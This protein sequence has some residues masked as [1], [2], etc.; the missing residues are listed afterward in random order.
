M[1]EVIEYVRAGNGPALVEVESYRWFGHST[2]D[3]GVYRT[4]EEVAEWK[5][6]DPLKKYRTYLT[7]NKIATDEELDAIEA[8]VAEQVEAA[9]KFAQESPDPDISVAYEDVFVD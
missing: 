1:Q 7:E 4:K 2:A 8:Q 5:A 9:V 3:A 6:K